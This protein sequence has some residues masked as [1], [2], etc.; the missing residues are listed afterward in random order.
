MALGAKQKFV[1]RPTNI[2]PRNSRE[3]GSPVIACARYGSLMRKYTGC[4]L[5]WAFRS[6]RWAA[7]EFLLR[8]SNHFPRGRTSAATRKWPL[9][10][11]AG[12]CAA[13]FV[14]ALGAS[15][16]RPAMA[17]AVHEGAAEVSRVQVT[18]RKSRTIK[19]TRP[20]TS[21]V[22]GAPEIAD[23][24]PM[25]DTVIY[26]QGK[27]VGTTNVSIFDK[28]KQLIAVVDIDVAID[29]QH[30]SKNILSS[31][32]SAGIRVS[33]ANDQVVLS[34][35]A[36]DA[37]D[38][39]RAVSIAKAMA[40]GVSII[41]AMK[42][43]PSQQVMLK[44]RYLEVNRNAAREIGVNWY[45][46]NANGTRGVNT[47]LGKPAHAVPDPA[48]F[49]IPLFQSLNT[50]ASGATTQP[51]GVAIGNLL[52]NGATIDVMI[53]ALETKGLVRSLAEPDLV[54]LSGD[55]ASFLAGGEI[56]VP[57]IQPTSGGTTVTVEYKPFGVQLSFVPTVLASG[58][59]NLRMTP[60]VSAL[61]Y[62]NAVIISGYRIPALSKRETQTTIELRD[63]QSFAISGLLQ[64]DA[65]RDV[66][67]VPWLGT[68][69]VLGAL[70][71]SSSYQQK[72]TDLVV[73]V[74]PHLVAPAV[75]GQQ[76]ASPLDQRLPAN[77]VDFF[78][79][80][81][82]DVRKKYDA[83]VASGGGLKGPYG[84]IVPV[85]GN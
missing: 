11:V 10:G 75:P 65:T 85:T 76:L 4:P 77:D 14:T 31:I 70:F 59:I 46:A 33:S 63:G 71:R 40:P 1:T 27:K 58:I 49:G 78:L 36:K 20:F 41:N 69:P 16:P 51:F 34:G 7:H 26:I 64:N 23:V 80:G 74:T 35:M 39:E 81:R 53:N 84:H 15:E 67:Q 19:L 82:M 21:A 38:A 52:S 12:L 42:V 66:S 50:L 48:P 17:G 79:M 57:V 44:V 2:P 72:E 25:S 18:H 13:A 24:L 43:A 61:D 62:T 68:L 6:M 9:R 3:S 45:G 22:V 30:I 32:E 47:G 28:E 56:P 60:S 54:A 5:S 29:A 8:A 55:T 37:P 73:I 83:Y